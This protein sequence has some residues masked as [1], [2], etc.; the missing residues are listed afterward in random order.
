MYKIFFLLLIFWKK[1]V[2]VFVKQKQ[3]WLQWLNDIR[4]FQLM[5]L[6]QLDEIQANQ[7]EHPR[8]ASK[9]LGASMTH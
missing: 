1:H 8:R 2:Q 3:Q 4:E 9:K 5:E 7:N 6:L